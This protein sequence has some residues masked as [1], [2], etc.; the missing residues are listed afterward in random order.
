MPKPVMAEAEIESRPRDSEIR[1]PNADLP[2]ALGKRITEYQ[3][4]RAHV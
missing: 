4:G 1:L 2:A 3:I